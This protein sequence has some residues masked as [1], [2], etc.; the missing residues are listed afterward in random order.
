MPWVLKD[1]E[2]KTKKATT[3]R[4][5]RMWLDVANGELDKH[6]DERRAIMAANGV[7]AK[8]VKHAAHKAKGK[9]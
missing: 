6:S 7:V 2:R 4:L 8:A 5:K 9:R 3:P 1:V